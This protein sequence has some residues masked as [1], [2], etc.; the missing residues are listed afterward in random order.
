MLLKPETITN[1]LKKY[2]FLQVTA[3]DTLEFLH[4]HVGVQPVLSHAF[5][6]G[7]YMWSEVLVK[8]SANLERYEPTLTR[9][10]GQVFDSP[11]GTPPIFQRGFAIALFP[12]HAFLCFLFER[13]IT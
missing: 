2:I 13:I 6:A 3:S 8:A 5:S 11:P 1:I 10:K 7:N 4:E 9:V 12:Q